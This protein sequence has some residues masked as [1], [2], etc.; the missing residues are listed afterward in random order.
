MTAIKAPYVP[1]GEPLPT[2]PKT[3]IPWKDHIG[4]I[5]ID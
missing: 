2:A 1:R 3:C 4:A 5:S